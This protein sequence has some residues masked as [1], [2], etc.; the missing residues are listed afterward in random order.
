MKILVCISNVPD[1]TSKINFKNSDTEFDS[2]GIQYIINPNDEFGLTRAVWFQQKDDSD[3]TVLTVG[4]S[5]CEPILRKCLAIGANRA[6]RINSNPIDAFQV[7]YEIAGFCKKEKFDL[8]IT[9]RESID[10][11]GGMVG[12]LLSEILDY[13][14]VTNCIDLKIN[15]NIAYTSREIDGGKEECEAQL[16]II[17]GSQKGIVEEKD[18]II[19]NMRGI[20]QARQKPLSVIE[21]IGEKFKSKSISFE[22]PKEKNKIKI[23]NSENVDELIN[24][25]HNEAKVI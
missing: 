23:V 11:N 15:N 10:Y 2:S 7:A 16:P 6:V 22:K 21:S 13:N 14:Y 1:T 9:G 18:L 19:P 3:I 4:D 5:S 12:G 24:L 17:I 25:L 20:M 8:I